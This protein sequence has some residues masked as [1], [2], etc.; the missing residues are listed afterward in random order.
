MR[1][2]VVIVSILLHFVAMDVY[3]QPSCY[4]QLEGLTCVFANNSELKGAL[5]ASFKKGT[6]VFSTEG[7]KK[8][9]DWGELDLPNNMIQFNL[10]P[11]NSESKISAGDQITITIT[12]KSTSSCMAGATGTKTLTYDGSG[13][14]YDPGDELFLTHITMKLPEPT[15]TVTGTAFC[16]GDHNGKSVSAKLTNVP[17]GCTIDWGNGNITTAATLVAG[18]TSATGNIGAGVTATLSGITAKL[19]DASGKDLATSKPYTVTVNPKPTVSISPT[20]LC[21]GAEITATGGGSYTWTA[22][23]TGTNAKIKAPN[24]TTATTTTYT[25]QVKSAQNCTASKSEQITVNPLPTVTLSSDVDRRCVNGK[26]VTLTANA[27]GGSG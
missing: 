19:K 22:G 20:E 25:V 8:I 3:A 11:M 5:E 9:T 10:D 2:I 4:V 17:A 12:I 23:G 15:I 13:F 26:D 14:L 24:V 18:A 21:S 27:N 7:S 6:L 16:A 1:K